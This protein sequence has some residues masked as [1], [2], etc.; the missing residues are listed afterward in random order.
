MPQQHQQLESLIK[1]SQ[2]PEKRKTGGDQTTLKRLHSLYKKGQLKQMND[3]LFVVSNV[4]KENGSYDAISVPK[5]IFPGLIQALHLK[6]R[7]PSK[8]QL[9]KLVSRHF[10]A[11]GSNNIVEEITANGKHN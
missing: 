1:T 11:P 10:Y 3:G 2:S 7:H 8:M 4:D 9:L 5:Q 6:L